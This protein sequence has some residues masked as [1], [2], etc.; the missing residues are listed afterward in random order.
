MFKKTDRLILLIALSLFLL[1]PLLNSQS[2]ENGAFE[3]K[4]TIENDQPLPGVTVTAT[5]TSGAGAKR[6]TVTDE[7]GRFRF[8]ALMPGLYDLEA[9]LEGFQ[10]AKREGIRLQVGSTLAVDF[11]MNLGKIE[12]KVT[13]AGVAPMV[14]V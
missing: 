8:P 5:N 7:N 10:T 4:I 3:G 2:K 6:V 1:N 11:R 9:Q 13:V 12:E 14:D